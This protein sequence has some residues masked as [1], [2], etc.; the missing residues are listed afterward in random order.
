MRLAAT[1]DRLLRG[2]LPVL[3]SV[4]VVP[5]GEVVVLLLIVVLHSRDL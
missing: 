4:L 2:A 5:G 3:L 1:H